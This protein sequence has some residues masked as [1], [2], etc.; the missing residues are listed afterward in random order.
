MDDTMAWIDA[1]ERDRLEA[2]AARVPELEWQVAQNRLVGQLAIRVEQALATQQENGQ[3]PDLAEEMAIATVASEMQSQ[4]VEEQRDNLLREKR[5]EFTDS[6]RRQQGPIIRKQLEVEM[7]ADGTFDRLR[8][9]VAAEQA[10]SLRSDL[11]QTKREEY[12][13][14]VQEPEAAAATL[15]RIKEEYM[16]SS[17]A[18]E[19]RLQVRADHEA[20]CL[21]EAKA[22]GKIQIDAEE[23]ERAE[24]FKDTYRQKFLKSEKAAQHRKAVRSRLEDEWRGKTAEDALAAIGDEE[25]MKLVSEK[26]RLAR[27]KVGRQNRATELLAD[28]ESRGVDIAKLEA[29]DSLVLYL[30]ETIT[31]STRRNYDY[32][33]QTGIVYSRKL[34]LVSRG[35]GKYT[36]RSDSLNDF[37]DP[38]IRSSALQGG[39]VITV[40]N[41]IVENGEE[42]LEPYVAMDMTLYYDDDTTTPEVFHCMPVPVVNL[43][44]NGVSARKIDFSRAKAKS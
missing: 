24:G 11:E 37:D 38:W 17:S 34:A 21:D 4:L 25:S 14:A 7:S 26:A 3:I 31:E 43:E 44:V 30:G 41:R 8:E 40:G 19:L 22:E 29:G 18:E 23:K 42:R 28:F 32:V 39:L 2:A 15:A 20:R 36:V 16:G 10:A 9:E 12:E 13:R 35:E 1:N 5:A 6:Y 33:T 27:E